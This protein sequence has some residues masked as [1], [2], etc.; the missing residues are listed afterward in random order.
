MVASSRLSARFVSERAISRGVE[1]EAF[2]KV[3]PASLPVIVI[4]NNAGHPQSSTRS[5]SVPLSAAPDAIVGRN[6]PSDLRFDVAYFPSVS[7]SGSTFEKRVLVAGA[8]VPFRPS[9]R[10]L[11]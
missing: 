8:G 10:I 1:I 3:A 9:Q 11:L 7:L 5:A 2:G 6:C 4:N